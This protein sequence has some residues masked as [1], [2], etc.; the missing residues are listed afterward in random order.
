LEL[1]R[2]LVGFVGLSNP[3]L[4]MIP[5][6]AAAAIWDWATGGLTRGR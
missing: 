2:W 6:F 1:D 3:W 4:V 5:G